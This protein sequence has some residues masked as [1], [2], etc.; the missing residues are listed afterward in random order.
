MPSVVGWVSSPVTE[1]EIVICSPSRIQAAPS[2]NTIR[3]W[4][5]DHFSRSR[6][7][8][9][10]DLIGRFA[11]SATALMRAPLASGGP[12]SASAP[13]EMTPPG[14]ELDK[15]AHRW[16]AR[17]YRGVFTTPPR[18]LARMRNAP[19]GTSIR[20]ARVRDGSGVDAGVRSSSEGERV[21]LDVG[22]EE[23]DRQRAPA[24]SAVLAHE[25]V[26]AAVPQGPAAVLVDIDAARRA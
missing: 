2:P 13:S 8:G 14:A 12:G 24:S 16:N 10:V 6:R 7:A 5:G 22:R 1:L 18:R 26:H 15:W 3:V 17:G 23:R 4:N 19:T 20:P 9:I 21:G 11:G 25:L